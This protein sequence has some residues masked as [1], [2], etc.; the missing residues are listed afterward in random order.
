MQ[1]ISLFSLTERVYRYCDLGRPADLHA[2]P[3]KGIAGR[4]GKS[5][6]SYEDSRIVFL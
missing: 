4:L 2:H 5:S 3:Q 6:L 1:A